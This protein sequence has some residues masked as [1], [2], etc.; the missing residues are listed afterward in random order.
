VLFPVSKGTFERGDDG[1]GFYL[2]LGGES[3][4][5]T[6]FMTQVVKDYRRS[7]DYLY[8]RNDIDLN[9]ISFYGV[10]WGPFIGAIL[11]AVDSRLKTN[12][13]VSGGLR[14]QGRPEVNM[15][16]FVGHVY[17]PTL[18][19]NGKYDSIFPVDVYIQP[20]HK[21]LS[22]PERDKKLVLFDTDHIPP[23]DGMIRETLGWFD[24]YMGK[25]RLQ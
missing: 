11:A 22:T 3:H 2:H 6:E 16:N 18:M 25:V 14:G 5:Y 8:T 19:L 13:F 17:I 4:Q 9:N 10:S 20:M 23:S 1:K 15:L 12:V 24:K 21:A 7:I